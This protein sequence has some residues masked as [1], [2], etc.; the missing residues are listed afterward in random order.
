[1]LENKVEQHFVDCAWARG[2]E[3]RKLAYIGRRGAPDRLLVLPGGRVFFVELK[4]PG[5]GAADHQARE[6]KRLRRAG[7]DV[8]VLDTLEAVDSFFNEVAP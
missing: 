2:G 3:V 5:A 6:H 7:A 8:R 4:R 1:M